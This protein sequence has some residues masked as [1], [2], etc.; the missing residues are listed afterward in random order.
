MSRYVLCR[1]EGGLNDM[2][3]QIERCCRYAEGTDR[4]VV[5]D[6][7]HPSSDHFRDRLDR[8]LSLRQSRLVLA[9]EALID[10][11]NRLDAYPTHLGGQLRDYVHWYDRHSGQYFCSERGAL[12]SFDFSTDHPHAVLVH[13]QAGR[14]RS[15]VFG[16][17]RLKLL[18]ALADELTRRWEALGGDYAAIHV[19]HTDYRTNYQAAFPI[20]EGGPL[21]RLFVATDNASVLDAFRT[22]LGPERVFSFAEPLF[23]AGVAIHRH[24]VTGDALYARNRDAILDVLLLALARELHVLPLENRTHGTYSGYSQLALDLHR[25]KVL[26]QLAI[27]PARIRVGLE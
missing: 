23:P 9:D 14:D 26:L 5:V 16:L 19:C 3:S 21:R 11:L 18:P 17:L 24:P 7:A 13:H 10:E 2:L 8:Y 6:T 22:R 15:S 4:I 27:V 20:I 25:A 1:P 12:L